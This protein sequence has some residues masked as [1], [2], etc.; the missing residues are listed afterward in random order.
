M[1]LIIINLHRTLNGAFALKS[2]LPRF[3]PFKSMGH[4]ECYTKTTI[5]P[6]ATHI[7]RIQSVLSSVL[8][9]TLA[10][11]KQLIFIYVLKTDT[12][13]DEV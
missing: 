6:V 9:L 8:S 7:P 12:Y 2:C 3:R 1:H 4:P 13:R 10:A 11:K 5:Y